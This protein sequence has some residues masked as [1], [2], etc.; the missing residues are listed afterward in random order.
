MLFL[1]IPNRSFEGKQVYRFG[2]ANIFID[3]NV[4]FIF[5]NGQWIPLRLNDLVSKAI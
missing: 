1:P 4:L 3:K 5:E 2:N